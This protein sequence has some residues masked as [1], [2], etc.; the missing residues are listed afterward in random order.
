MGETHGS[1][2]LHDSV[3][4]LVIIS[5]TRAQYYSTVSFVNFE[6]NY[7]KLLHSKNSSE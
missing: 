4:A 1:Y 5:L 7:D 2:K 6:R 3:L